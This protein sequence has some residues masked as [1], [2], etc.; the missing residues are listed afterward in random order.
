MHRLSS[1]RPASLATLL[2]L[3]VVIVGCSTPEASQVRAVDSS[4]DTIQFV[5]DEE[6]ANDE[7]LRGIVE[8]QVIDGSLENCHRVDTEYR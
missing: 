8:C 1:Y 7:Y 6:R 5:F 4:A 2:L 3:L